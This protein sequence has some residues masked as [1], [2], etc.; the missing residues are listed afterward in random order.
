[1]FPKDKM[2]IVKVQGPPSISKG[3]PGGKGKICSIEKENTKDKTS[4]SRDTI[5]N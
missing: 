4:V 2:S 1:M 5:S 3:I